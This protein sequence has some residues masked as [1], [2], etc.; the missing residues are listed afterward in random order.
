MWVAAVTGSYSVTAPL[1]PA[2]LAR[3]IADAR[4][5]A[6]NVQGYLL[7]AQDVLLSMAAQLE[8]LLAALDQQRREA[9]TKEERA[10][11]L[12]A[13]IRK[14]CDSRIEESVGDL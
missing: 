4:V 9:S 6:G 5:I 14:L 12:L 13:V 10:A 11:E 2:G 8:R 1:D 7:H 3:L